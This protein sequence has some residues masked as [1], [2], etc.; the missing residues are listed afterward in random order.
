MEKNIQNKICDFAKQ[1]SG[2]DDLG[3]NILSLLYKQTFSIN[4]SG[5]PYLAD[6]QIPLHTDQVTYP[7]YKNLLQT[8]S[9]IYPFKKY[10]DIIVKGSAKNFDKKKQFI[11][12]VNFGT[13]M[14]QMHI[15]GNQKTY[16]DQHKKIKFSDIEIIDEVPLQFNFAYGGIDKEAEKKIVIKDLELLKKIDP[17]IDFLAGNP[18][19]Y[20]RNPEGKGFIV[21]FNKDT[22]EQ[23]ELPNIQDPEN[24]LTPE[25]L[26]LNNPKKWLDMPIPYATDW[27]SPI[28]FPRLAY[29]GFMDFESRNTSMLKEVKNKLVEKDIFENKGLGK[30]ANLRFSNCGSHALQIA[31]NIPINQCQLINIHPSNKNFIFKLPSTRPKLYVDGRNGKLTPTISVMDTLIIEPNKNS[32]SIVWRGT[33]K[34][35]RP[36]LIHELENMPF[37]VD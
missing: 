37:Q 28:W 26:I 19:R 14:H 32:F 9:D 5:E 34:A 23:L 24:L 17:T 27:V 16:L 12:E 7:H 15:Q 2:Y 21:D 25:N 33:A 8:E 6:E 29:A 36:Y 22:I 31:H 10:C 1:V 11:A 3:N 13:V 30:N 18:Y 35:L 4:K 20:P